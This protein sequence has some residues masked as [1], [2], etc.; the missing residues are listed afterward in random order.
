MSKP[1][2]LA[3]TL[4]TLVYAGGLDEGWVYADMVRGGLGKL[5]FDCTTQQVAAWLGRMARED[6]PWVERRMS[7]F[8]RELEYRV[9]RYGKMDVENNWPLHV[10][11]AW[12]EPR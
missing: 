5:G 11:A 3:I 2:E 12:L 1:S 10:W 8:G 7:R 9:T 6:A 4:A